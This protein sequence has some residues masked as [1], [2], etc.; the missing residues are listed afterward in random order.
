MYYKEHIIK[1]TDW[2]DFKNKVSTT[3]EKGFTTDEEFIT[4]IGFE[5]DKYI[6]IKENMIFNWID[7]ISKSL[8]HSFNNITDEF[9]TKDEPIFSDILTQTRILLVMGSGKRTMN[10]FGHSNSTDGLRMIRS[11]MM[12]DKIKNTDPT[13]TKYDHDLHKDVMKRYVDVNGQYLLTTTLHSD[14]EKINNIIQYV[15]CYILLQK[16]KM[17]DKSIKKPKFLYRGIRLTQLY[18]LFKDVKELEFEKHKEYYHNTAHFL[19]LLKKYLNGK[20]TKILLEGRYCSFTSSYD[21]AKYFANNEG[22][23][24]K[25]KAEDVDIVASELTEELFQDSNAFNNKKEKEY[26]VDVTNKSNILDDSIYIV[27]EDYYKSIV[28]PLYVNYIS[29][30][31]VLAIY[32]YKFGDEIYKIEASGY[33]ASSDKFKKIFRVLNSNI[34]GRGSW[35]LGRNEFMK[36]F[37]FNPIPTEKNLDL[38][39][40]FKLFKKT[41]YSNKREEIVK[42]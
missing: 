3:I 1:F 40:N 31:D 28:S 6:K 29:H 30:D 16:I 35:D 27:H 32:D 36:E 4:D 23:I 13:L 15:W 34:S 41:S 24:L 2:S 7:S 21:I 37:G 26:I 14:I 20:N 11:E 22:I 25:V 38:I 10:M 39:S 18:T 33:W 5:Y 8:I 17:K 42:L 9:P 19:I 12:L